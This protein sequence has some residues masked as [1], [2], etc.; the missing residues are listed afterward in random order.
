MACAGPGAMVGI[1]PIVLSGDQ[2]ANHRPHI[3]RRQPPYAASVPPAIGDAMSS[4]IPPFRPAA[5][6]AARL[7]RVLCGRTARSLVTAPD[8]RCDVPGPERE[9]R[10]RQLQ[11]P[12]RRQ[13]LRHLHHE[14]ERAPSAQ[15]HAD[16]PANDDYPR[17]SADGRMIAFWSTRTGPGNPTGDQEIFVM[18]ANGS[19][20]RQ[21]TYNTVDDGAPAWSPNGDRLVF[22][23]WLDNDSQADLMTVRVNGTDERNLTRSPGIL[24]RHADLVAGRARDRVHARRQRARE[25]HLHDPPGRL[26]SAGTDRHAHR[27]GG[28]GLVPRREADRLPRRCRDARRAMGHLRDAPRRRLAADPAHDGHGLPP[29]VVARRAQDR[30]RQ[31]SPR[32][33]SSSSRCARTAAARRSE[34]CTRRAGDNHPDWQPV[35]KDARAEDDDD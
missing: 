29:G 8:R 18:N 27:R 14:S 7:M 9:D 15:P 19:G 5:L 21:V 4:L 11:R 20:L 32:T 22:H 26:P 30:L 35:P 31:R 17:W 1:R 25:R 3:Y 33:T 10:V 23:R 16:S 13:H 24:D 2:Y 28:S 6:A 12:S 34:P